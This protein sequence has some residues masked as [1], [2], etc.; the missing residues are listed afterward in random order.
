MVCV[1]KGCSLPAE[2]SGRPS[3]AEATSNPECRG[4]GGGGGLSPSATGAMMNLPLIMSQARQNFTQ[5]LK[6]NASVLIRPAN[7]V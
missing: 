1:L 6:R 4:E 2:R 5:G 7:Q 3:G